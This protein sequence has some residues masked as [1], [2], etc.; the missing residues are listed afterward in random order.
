LFLV[1]LANRQT[2]LLFIYQPV[3]QIVMFPPAPDFSACNGGFYC[4]DVRYK[5]PYSDKRVDM[6]FGI[7][8]AD[9]LS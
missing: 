5:L 6:S 3:N 1:V 7:Y 8:R 4:F 2:Y 9:R